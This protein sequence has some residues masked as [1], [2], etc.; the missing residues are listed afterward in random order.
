MA[1]DLAQARTAAG[2]GGA[3]SGL[4]ILALSVFAG[5]TTEM[6]PVGLLPE[7]SRAFGVPESTAGLLVSLYA[8][9]AAAL[10]LPL[11]L[12]T[13]VVPRKRLLLITTSCFVVSNLVSALAPSFAIFAVG[14]AFGGAAHALFFSVCI[15][16]ATRLVPAAQTGRALALMS[17]G[18]SAGFVL[19]VPL[20]TALGNAVGWRGA[21]AAL[22]ALMVL[23]I[24]LISVKLP[25]VNAPPGHT[26]PAPG[27]R[28]RLVAVLSSHTLLYSGHYV[29]YTYVSVL[30]LRS[31]APTSAVG[32]ILLVFGVVGLLGVWLASG[33]LDRRPRFSAVVIL[34]IM[35]VAVAGVGVAFPVL[36]LVIVAGAVWNGAFGPVPSLYQA[37]AVRTKA[38]SPDIAGAW[39]VATSNIGI[40]LGAAVGGLALENLGMRGVAWVATAFIAL[41][42]LGVVVARRAFPATP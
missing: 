2:L 26:R 37:A 3:R 12:A 4:L 16:Y 17:A 28:R 31:H 18:V 38:T 25:A 41:A 11:T 33:Q 5:V 9:M 21:F 39:V 19:G 27:R 14:R 15:G 6:L 10:A 35:G 7:I 24:V 36:A 40:A 30:L 1:V 20:A 8:V 29:L 42:I 13:R 23:A 34:S 22:A 32:P